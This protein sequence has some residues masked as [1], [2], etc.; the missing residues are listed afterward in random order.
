MD[1][2]SNAFVAGKISRVSLVQETFL[3]P[4]QLEASG[5]YVVQLFFLPIT[6]QIFGDQPLALAPIFQSLANGRVLCI[7]YANGRAR[8]F[9]YANNRLTLRRSLTF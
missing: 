2:H 9:G 5:V 1:A 4:Q 6:G 8:F 7:G 3:L